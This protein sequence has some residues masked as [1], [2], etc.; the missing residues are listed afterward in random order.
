MA[1]ET[2]IPGGTTTPAADPTAAQKQGEN[3]NTPPAQGV[4]AEQMQAAIQAAVNPIFAHIRKLSPAEKAQGD[5]QG[6]GQTPGS[7]L[8][9]P[10]KAFQAQVKE[11]LDRAERQTRNTAIVQAASANGVPAD[12]INAFKA[13]FAAQYGP[14]IKVVAKGDEDAVI[15]IDEIGTETD[16]K[17]T[18]ANF[19]RS[20]DGELFKPAVQT[21]RSG[22]IGNSQSGQANR[23]FFS[24]LSHEEQDKLVKSGQAGAYVKEDMRSGR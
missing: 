20:A 9:D 15:H 21:P 8:S 10:Q 24:E 4:T 1:G 22:S 3:G 17:T 14:A 23:P 2:I 13:V 11:K 6:S 16:L 19:L 18:V 5:A 7:A 12:R